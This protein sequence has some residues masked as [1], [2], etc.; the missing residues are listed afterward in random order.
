MGNPNVMQPVADVD[1]IPVGTA[2]VVEVEDETIA[3]VHAEDGFFALTNTC[4]HSGGPLGDGKVEDDSIYCPWH[5]Y[6]FE[7]ASGDHAQGL[8]LQADTYEVTVQDGQVF[9]SV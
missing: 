4:P 1:D 3:L 6:Q 5:G 2:G 8:P 7:L 9:V